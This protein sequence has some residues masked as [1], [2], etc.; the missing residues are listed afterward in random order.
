MKFAPFLSD[1]L[2][3]CLTHNSPNEVVRELHY[4]I[5]ANAM[6]SELDKKLA[7]ELW[8]VYEGHKLSISLANMSPAD[9]SEPL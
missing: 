5:M 1:I 6:A 2:R 4:E 3:T 8:E 9:R 7:A